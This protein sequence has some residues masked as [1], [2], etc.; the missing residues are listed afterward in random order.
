[1]N[2]IIDVTGSPEVIYMYAC[3]HRIT[4][5]SN[6]DNSKQAVVFKMNV[7]GEVMFLDI[8][9]ADSNGARSEARA[10]KY[11][12][13]T[14]EVIILIQANSNSRLGQGLLIMRIKDSNDGPISG[15]NIISLGTNNVQTAP[16]G[17]FYSKQRNQYIFGAQSQGY[18]TLKVDQLSKSD[19]DV[20]VFNFNI[21][22]DV[23]CLS[24]SYISADDIEGL[25]TRFDQA[26]PSV[27]RI[28][29]VQHAP[30]DV[31]TILGTVED[32][33]VFLSYPASTEL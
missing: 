19:T 27:A 25:K 11:D 18:K 8:F 30:E 14:N 7:Y 13:S 23:G 17:I 16:G 21:S 4:D 28:S 20:F 9:G 12:D 26:I 5:F 6:P 24:T 33:T 29:K 31:F 32:P 3:G 22:Q 10:I 1:M 15:G 2:E